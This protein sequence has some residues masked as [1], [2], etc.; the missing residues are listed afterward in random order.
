MQTLA[1]QWVLIYAP[2]NEI[3]PIPGHIALINDEFLAKIGAQ[4]VEIIASPAWNPLVHKDPKCVVFTLPGTA[5][6]S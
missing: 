5:T 3:D 2:Y 1:S 6:K 4:D